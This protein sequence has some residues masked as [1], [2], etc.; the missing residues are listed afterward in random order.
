MPLHFSAVWYVQVNAF[1]ASSPFAQTVT[2]QYRVLVY[3]M[4]NKIIVELFKDIGSV[5]EKS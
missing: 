1:Q 2:Q 4:Y 5:V 3:I